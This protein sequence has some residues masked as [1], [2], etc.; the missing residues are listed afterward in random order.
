MIVLPVVSILSA[1]Y[2]YIQALKNAMHPKR[3]GFL[4]L[5]LGP[6]VWPFFSTHKRMH[7]LRHKVAQA[8]CFKA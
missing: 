4:G 6:L 7:E 5:C 3:W 1:L 8:C 2:F